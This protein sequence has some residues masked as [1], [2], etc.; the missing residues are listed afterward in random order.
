VCGNGKGADLITG[1][2]KIIFFLANDSTVSA[3][4]TGIQYYTESAVTGNSYNHQYH[5]AA[6]QDYHI[7]SQVSTNTYNHQYSI[8]INA[9]KALSQ[10]KIKSI[11]KYGIGHYT[12]FDIKGKNSKKLSN[13]A[14]IFLPVIGLI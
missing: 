11:R 10:N 2:E 4:S 1:K 13:L 9:I 5:S 8:S 14:K 12:D 3:Y 6:I 7:E